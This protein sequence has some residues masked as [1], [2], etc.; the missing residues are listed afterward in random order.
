MIHLTSTRGTPLFVRAE[1]ILFVEGFDFG[2]KSECPGHYGSRLTLAAGQWSE[3]V[4]AKESP[5]DIAERMA[6][7]VLLKRGRELAGSSQ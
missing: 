6:A 2:E 3:S 1:A 5:A 7:A 4:H